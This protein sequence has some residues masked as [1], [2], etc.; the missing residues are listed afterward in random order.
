MYTHIH[1]RAH[2]HNKQTNKIFQ[3]WNHE[4]VIFSYA[5]FLEL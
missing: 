2:T 1:T 3:N 4:K 5:L